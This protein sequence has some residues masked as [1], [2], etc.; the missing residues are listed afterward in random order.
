MER[1]YNWENPKGNP[2]VFKYEDLDLDYEHSNGYT[3]RGNATSWLFY[4]EY[5]DRFIRGYEKIGGFSGNA[6]EEEHDK[7]VIDFCE[8]NNILFDKNGNISNK[9]FKRIWKNNKEV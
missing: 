7:F 3:N 2:C 8:E 1:F 6:T 4:D 9:E 5:N